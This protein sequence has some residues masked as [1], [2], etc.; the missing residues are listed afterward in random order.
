MYFSPAFAFIGRTMVASFVPGRI[1]KKT[2]WA[3]LGPGVGGVDAI[4]S[5]PLGFMLCN[6]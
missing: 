2:P 6:A 3:F 5:S 1:R 4:R